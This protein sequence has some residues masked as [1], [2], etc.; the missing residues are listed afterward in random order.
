M[1][2]CAA[3]V[4]WKGLPVWSGWK[5]LAE[6]YPVK[7]PFHGVWQ[8]RTSGKVGIVDCNCCRDVGTSVDYLYLS[9][10]SDRLYL[11]GA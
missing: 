6:K 10:G 8:R 5:Y 9:A 11:R 7:Q 1:G 3:M 2:I 4:V